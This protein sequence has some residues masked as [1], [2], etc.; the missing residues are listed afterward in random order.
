M[1][2]YNAPY[3]VT[4]APDNPCESPKCDSTIFFYK[5]LIEFL[6]SVKM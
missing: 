4:Q 5:W 6:L 3:V 1:T 2:A